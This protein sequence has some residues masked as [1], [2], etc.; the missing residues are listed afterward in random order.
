[1]VTLETKDH[2]RP[3]AERE[4]FMAEIRSRIP[5]CSVYVQTCNR[6]EI[7]SG[8]GDVPRPTAMHLFRMA[9]GLESRL[10]GETAVLGQVKQAYQQAAAL[11]PL[12]KN[13]HRLFQTALKVGKRV[14]T[15]T[16]L[17]RGAV[18]HSQ[19]A[20]NLIRNLAGDLSQAHI[21]ILGVNRLNRSIVKY[22]ADQACQTIFLSTRSY[23]KALSLSQELGG[24]AFP[25]EELPRHLAHTDV[26]ISATSAP[27]AVV[28]YGDVPRDRD[29]II[30][31]LA[32]PRD[33]EATVGTLPKVRLFNLEDVETL[34]LSETKLRTG[35]IA[36]AERIV[37][38]EVE[39]FLYAQAQN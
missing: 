9:S 5:A 6:V 30:V 28:R 37:T 22:L 4:Q 14:R 36:A 33:V 15:E 7:Y 10:I 39:S 35:E 32:V 2:R 26:L 19:A 11:F 24:Q 13:L 17:S 38:E 34:A 20:V 27:H 1:M 3:L 25:L 16:G 29:L 23:D 21:T 18:G 8:D 31:D 12:P